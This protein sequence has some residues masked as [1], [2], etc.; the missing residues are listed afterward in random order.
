MRITPP[1]RSVSCTTSGIAGLSVRIFD[2]VHVIGA[3]LHHIGELA[4]AFARVHVQHL[5]PNEIL[6]EVHALFQFHFVPVHIQHLIPQLFCLLHGVHAL[7]MQQH[8]ALLQA[9]GSHRHRLLRLAQV[10]GIE[11]AQE[12]RI[13]AP[14]HDFHVATKS[15]DVDDLS[16]FKVLFHEQSF[17]Y[18]QEQANI[19]VRLHGLF[20]AVPQ[21]I[22]TAIF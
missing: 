7:Q 11:F 1:S 5:Q 16:D 13:V 15:V 3:G 4:V 18:I 17:L 20:V 12:F 6:D 22:S 9:C 14:R 21:S 2:L 8:V 10:Q 19:S